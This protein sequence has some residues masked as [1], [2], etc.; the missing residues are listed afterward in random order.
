MYLVVVGV[1]DN[2][3]NS[4]PTRGRRGVIPVDKLWIIDT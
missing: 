2:V 4:P 1:V 3:D